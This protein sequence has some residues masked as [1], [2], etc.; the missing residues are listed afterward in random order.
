MTESSPKK[1]EV[2]GPRQIYLDSLSEGMERLWTSGA[3]TDVTI[4]VGN[5][6][7]SCHKTLLSAMSSYFDAMFSSGMRE[8]ISGHVTFPE[9]DPEL[10]E[11]VIR[12]LYT[13]KADITTDNAIELL[14]IA[15]V[16]QIKS[17]QLVCENYLNPH[18]TPENCL[19]IWKLAVLHDCENLVSMAVKMVA[20]NFKVIHQTEEFL[21]LEGNEV[22]AIIKEDE[23][24]VESEDKLCDII[25]KWI[26]KDRDKR[27][28]DAGTIF[29]NIRLPFM[30]PEYLCNL[31]EAYKF[32]KDDPKCIKCINEAKRFHLLPARQQE[33]FSN[34]TRYRITSDTEEVLIL[35]GGCLTTSPPYSRSLHVPCYSFTFRKWYEIAPLPFDPG[36][37]FATCTYK[38]DIYITGKL[39]RLIKAQM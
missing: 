6:Q 4:E 37:E 9:M 10:F 17:F 34:Q 22:A 36:I 15:S 14:H 1:D 39:Y 19:K 26:K 23:L 29:E 38:T 30:K 32:L 8:S 20:R 7:F 3:Q 13:G 11:I 24:D 12:F 16:L 35:L 5:K 27:V 2:A 21:E 31:E 28:A 18:I 33:M 25:L